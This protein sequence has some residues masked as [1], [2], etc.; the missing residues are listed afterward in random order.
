M[1]PNAV[2]TQRAVATQRAVG[3]DVGSSLVK[4]VFARAEALELRILPTSDIERAALEIEAF[5]PECIGATGTGA[6]RLAERLSGD[7]RPVVEF[8]AWRAGTA[9]LLARQDETPPEN[10]L[11]A[12]LGTGTSFLLADAEGAR[13]VGGSALG[14]GTLV[15]LGQALVGIGEAERL[16]ALAAQGDRRAVD[17]GVADVDPDGSLGMSREFTAAFLAGLP[18][19]DARPA[20]VAHALNGMLAETLGTLA[21][22]MAAALGATRIVYGG[23][24]LRHN[25]ALRE[26]LAAYTFARAHVFLDDGEFAGALGA[27]EL[28]RRRA[29]G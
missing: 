18:L 26:I 21:S 29:D 14:G 19:A 15:A 22:A 24:T 11:I 13:H 1:I 12:S 5:A 20:D 9:W 2:P 3:V 27:L 28:E 7:V 8:E 17:L 25:P 16:S 4:L 6:A 10:D 23:G